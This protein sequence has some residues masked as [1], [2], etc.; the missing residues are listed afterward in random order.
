MR[1]LFMACSYNLTGLMVID[2]M[3]DKP[4]IFSIRPADCLKMS[5]CSLLIGLVI[6]VAFYFIFKPIGGT[7][8]WSIGGF[9]TGML[10]GVNIFSDDYRGIYI[11]GWVIGTVASGILIF[12]NSENPFLLIFAPLGGLLGALIS[13]LPE[14]ESWGD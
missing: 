9:A 5:I 8:S 7:L 3:N 4:H 12:M 1:D 11:L 14:D 10:I 13:V 2:D 6:A